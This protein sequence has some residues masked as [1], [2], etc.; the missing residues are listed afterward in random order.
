MK[1]K[2]VLISLIIIVALLAIGIFLYPKR[3]GYI[4]VEVPGFMLNLRGGLWRSV[5]IGPSTE[6]KEVQIG[7]YKPSYANY[8]KEQNGDKWQ[9]YGSWS[10]LP[11]VQVDNK[12]TV[13][14]RFGPPFLVRTDVKRNGRNV[15]IG[16]SLVGRTGELYDVRVRKNGQSL[17]APKLKIVDET[18][19]VLTTGRFEYG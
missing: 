6:P 7:T 12:E 14:L 1:K 13:S 4:K 11:E 9:L 3:T 5:T 16:L 17:S 19:T 2:P 18:G 15:T 8:F 10:N